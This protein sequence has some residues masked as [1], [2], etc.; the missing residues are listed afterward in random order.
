MTL[1]QIIVLI[2]DSDLSSNNKILL[3]SRLDRALGDSDIV[4][5]LE[6]EIKTLRNNI[7]Q[8]VGEFDV[9]EAIRITNMLITLDRILNSDKPVP[10]K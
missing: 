10:K 8:R 3:E 5:R 2:R 4:A 1:E 7:L 9:D 6:E